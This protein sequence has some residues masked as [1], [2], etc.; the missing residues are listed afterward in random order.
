MDKPNKLNIDKILKKLKILENLLIIN[1]VI[2]FVA[3]ESWFYPLIYG[4]SI[5]VSLIP[6]CIM[7]A[8]HEII[9]DIKKAITSNQKN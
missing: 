7:C 5:L 3:F 1:A 2:A 8:S 9:D 6:L 4:F